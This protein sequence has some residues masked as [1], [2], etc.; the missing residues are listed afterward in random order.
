MTDANI[1]VSG[2]SNNTSLIL[3][4]EASQIRETSSIST[5]ANIATK[6]KYLVPSNLLTK[7]VHPDLK[8]SFSQDIHPSS[9]YFGVFSHAYNDR[10]TGM[11][12]PQGSNNCGGTTLMMMILYGLT[13]YPGVTQASTV[14]DNH[15]VQKAIAL[16]STTLQAEIALGLDMRQNLTGFFDT[17]PNQF[18]P[19]N[20]APAELANNKWSL[21][22]F[23]AFDTAAQTLNAGFAAACDDFTGIGTNGNQQ[24]VDWLI[25]LNATHLKK[26]AILS[27]ENPETIPF[28]GGTI[29]SVLVAGTGQ[30]QNTFFGIAGHIYG[31]PAQMTGGTV[32]TD[33]WTYASEYA[34]DMRTLLNLHKT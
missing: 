6:F 27:G 32:P 28:N 10:L 17:Y 8:L 3:G 24:F 11:L 30:L 26:L 14:F 2:S 18:N 20:V 12:L 22:D 9:P 13:T 25:W 23:I 31:L 33:V 34:N 7:P 16:H 21:T 1:T 15:D 19:A 4:S 5:I 29:E